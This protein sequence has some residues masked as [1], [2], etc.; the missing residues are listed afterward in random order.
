MS[1][2]S[3][4]ARSTEG[5]ITTGKLRATS[6]EQVS[7]RLREH[8]LMPIEVEQVENSSL[9]QKVVFGG[10]VGD[11][12]LIL[13]SRQ[14]ASMISAGVPILQAVQVLSNQVSK[15]NF[16]QLLTDIAYDVE[17]GEALSSSMNK[18]TEVFSDFYLGVVR[19]GESSGQL[20]TS[21]LTLADYLERNYLFRRK[22]QAALLYPVFVLAVV[23]IL[24]I[25]MFTF[26]LPQLTI[27]FADAGVR[28]PWPTRLLIATTGFFS[29][30]W[31]IVL[32]A[33]VLLGIVLRSYLK[34]PDG[35]YTLSSYVLRI[36]LL[37]RLFQKVY[38]ARLTAILHMLFASHVPALDSLRL[39]EEA[40]GNRVYRRI[41]ETTVAAV[42]DGATISKVWEQEPY[43]PPMLTTMISVGERSGKTATAFAE[44][45]SYFT[46][47]VEYTL[48]SI[49]VLI[50]PVLVIILGLGVAMVVS[51]VLL[52]IYNLVLVL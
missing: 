14:L 51:A 43:I 18:H 11:K 49:T 48:Q 45:N 22:L 40:L 4:R 6:A 25:V 42:K 24:T 39:A 12:E 15:Q 29:S 31:Y 27:L 50:E 26:V 30:Y 33:I 46:R 32:L 3:Y 16:R 23:V 13:F 2:F 7:A 47:D 17:S 36:P 10:I 38:L 41:L 5:R 35:R 28:L 44:A 52:P 8:G 20:T 1:Q 19:T 21:L 37:S 9:W 34:T